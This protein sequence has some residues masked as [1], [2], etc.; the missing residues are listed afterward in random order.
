MIDLHAQGALHQVLGSMQMIK[1]LLA[2]II[3]AVINKK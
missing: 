1:A 2:G 3:L